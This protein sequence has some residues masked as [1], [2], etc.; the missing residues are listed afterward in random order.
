MAM[1][2]EVLS[3]AHYLKLIREKWQKLKEIDE[4]P[5]CRDWER[6]LRRNELQETAD[7]YKKQAMSRFVDF[8]TRVGAG[9]SLANW[10]P[11][12]LTQI[13]RFWFYRSS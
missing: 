3:Q 6:A 2:R 9:K 12:W 5:D 10:Q 11:S 7:S 1:N 8:K 13:N 4:L